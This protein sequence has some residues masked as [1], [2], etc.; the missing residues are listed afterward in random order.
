MTIQEFSSI[1]GDNIPDEL[2]SIAN[3]MKHL[4][5]RGFK[6]TIKSCL[7]ASGSKRYYYVAADTTYMFDPPCAAVSIKVNLNNHVWTIYFRHG[8]AWIQRDGYWFVSHLANRPLDHL[9]PLLTADA[10]GHWVWSK[11]GQG[12][13]FTAKENELWRM[14]HDA[15]RRLFEADKVKDP[16][17][18]P[19]QTKVRQ[20]KEPRV[21]RA[22]SASSASRV[23]RA[24]KKDV[25]PD[26]QLDF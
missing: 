24:S 3:E 12:I 19:K 1:F 5:E 22:S 10:L 8:N 20:P 7:T 18:E 6:P 4:V 14:V 25:G 11:C 9:E 2:A 23:A 15:C 13:G 16:I 17:E 26:L 21:A